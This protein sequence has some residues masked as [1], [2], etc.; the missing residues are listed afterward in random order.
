MALGKVFLPYHGLR[1]VSGP[2]TH[3]F[4]I[5][6]LQVM[7]HLCIVHL[8]TVRGL[9]MVYA[10]GVPAHMFSRVVSQRGHSQGK[11]FKLLLDLGLQRYT[12]K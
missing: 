5:T 7:V 4:N 3:R 2:K 11:T 10:L 8:N 9:T 6:V 12:V 1:Q